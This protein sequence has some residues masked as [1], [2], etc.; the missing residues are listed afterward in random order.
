M[1]KV[2]VRRIGNSLGVILPKDSGI[3]VG[4]S[5]TY[6]K[7][8]S[9]IQLDLSEAQKSHDRNLIEESFKDFE[10]GNTVTEKEMIKEFG[11]YGWGN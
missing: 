8:G 3:T 7:N 11:K 4:E 1:Q 9:I 5:L 2:K 10:E 6:Q